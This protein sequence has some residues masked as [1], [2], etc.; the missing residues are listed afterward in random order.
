MCD[1]LPHL[2]EILDKCATKF[3]NLFVIISN[4]KLVYVT[5]PAHL[6][7]YYLFRSFKNE[8]RIRVSCVSPPPFQ[9]LGSKTHLGT[10]IS[11]SWNMRLA[12]V[13]LG[14]EETVAEAAAHGQQC[15]PPAAAFGVLRTGTPPAP[16][17]PAAPK[18]EW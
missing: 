8:A 18:S 11:I 2:V 10:S 15:D 6:R 17:H 13:P 7:T 3:P 9:K 1:R 14:F 5:G 12:I 4:F 16:L